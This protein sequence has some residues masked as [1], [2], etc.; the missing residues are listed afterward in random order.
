[1]AGAESLCLKLILYVGK[2]VM[3]LLELEKANNLVSLDK[4]PFLKYDITTY[5]LQ[6][7]IKFRF[8]IPNMSSKIIG[9]FVGALNKSGN[10][11]Y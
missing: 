2:F 3:S 8:A 7:Y 1:M 5:H 10:G 9:C 6:K 4:E 11:E